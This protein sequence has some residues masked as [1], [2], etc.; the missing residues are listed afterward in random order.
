MIVI[1]IPRS[2]NFMKKDNFENIKKNLP[3]FQRSKE[4]NAQLT[5]SSSQICSMTSIIRLTPVSGGGDESPH[6]YLG[7]KLMSCSHCQEL[8]QPARW[9][10]ISCA[11]VNIPIRSRVSRLTQLLTMTIQLISF[12]TRW[13]GWTATWPWSRTKPAHGVAATGVPCGGVSRETTCSTN[14]IQGRELLSCSH[15]Q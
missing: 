7:W 5:S 4:I 3:C 2:W 11:R 9:L 10:L 14:T 15:S 12:R 6:C 13:T 8:C 1:D